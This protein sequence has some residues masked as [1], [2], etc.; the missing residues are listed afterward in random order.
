VG[1]SRAGQPL[2]DGLNYA[3]GIESSSEIYY[4]GNLPKA[5]EPRGVDP[6]TLLIEAVG[7]IILLMWIIIPIREFREI[8]KRVKTRNAAAS[9]VPPT[10]EVS[11]TSSRG[12]HA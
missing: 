5:G 8:L 2:D 10:R 12:P 6:I 1:R 3:S 11:P 7:V 9:E 4:T